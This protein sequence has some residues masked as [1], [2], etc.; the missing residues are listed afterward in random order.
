MAS[1][2]GKVVVCDNGTGVSSVAPVLGVHK[3]L[4][5]HLRAGSPTL[6]YS[7][8]WVGSTFVFSPLRLVP[9]Q[10]RME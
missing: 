9:I 3:V 1:T 4:R 5:R 2:A 6:V 8:E 10:W 7:M